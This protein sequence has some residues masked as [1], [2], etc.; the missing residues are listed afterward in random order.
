MDVARKMSAQLHIVNIFLLRIQKFL[1]NRKYYPSILSWPKYNEI[2]YEG[3]V[4]GYHD[5]VKT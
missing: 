5:D 2:P 4:L 1:S 3:F